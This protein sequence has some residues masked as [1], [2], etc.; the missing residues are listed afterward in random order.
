MVGDYSET[1]LRFR[2]RS[3]PPQD[4]ASSQLGYFLVQ[5]VSQHHGQRHTFFGFVGSVAKHQPLRNKVTTAIKANDIEKQMLDWIHKT[6]EPQ[7]KYWNLDITNVNFEFLTLQA[8]PQT[9][10]KYVHTYFH[11]IVS[12]FICFFLVYKIAKYG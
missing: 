5:L 4:A 12:D 10:E 9:F 6:S 7:I 2:V 1:Y 3:G 8:L 11:S